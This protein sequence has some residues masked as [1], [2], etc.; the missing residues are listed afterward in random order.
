MKGKALNAFR[1][2][3]LDPFDGSYEGEIRTYLGCEIEVTWKKG[4]LLLVRSTMLRKF[5]APMTHGTTTFLLRFFP[6]TDLAF[7]YSKLSKY[8][9]LR[10]KKAFLLDVASNKPISSGVGSMLYEVMMGH[11]RLQPFYARSLR[12]C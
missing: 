9:Q 7:A 12:A 8:V 10:M 1:A 11:Q 3:L 4:L 6:P 2:Q 5:Y